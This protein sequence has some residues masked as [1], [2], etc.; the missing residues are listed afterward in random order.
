MSVTVRTEVRLR[1]TDTSLAFNSPASRYSDWERS[2]EGLLE[3]SAARMAP[4]AVAEG[5]TI[6]KDAV[7]PWREA[8][9]A[10]AEELARVER[11]SSSRRLRPPAAAPTAMPPTKRRRPPASAP[12]TA[13]IISSV[14]L[15]ALPSVFTAS[16]SAKAVKMPVCHSN[17]DVSSTASGT[18]PATAASSARIVPVARA[19]LNAAPV[20]GLKLRENATAGCS[21]SVVCST[22][23]S[24]AV[25]EGEGEGVTEGVAVRVAV[26]DADAEPEEE[27]DAEPDRERLRVEDGDSPSLGV[28]AEVPVPAGSPA[29][30]VGVAVSDRVRV[31][32]GEFTAVMVPEVVAQPVD[33]KTGVMEPACPPRSAA[34]P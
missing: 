27:E 14:L 34:P 21:W 9:A 1:P 26:A 12:P 25:V 31:E 24:D 15:Y 11:N 30:P 20:P 5:A 22:M 3:R 4:A 32:V 16:L 8:S 6:T 2:L 23:P 28:G 17:T 18:A 33:V 10:K 19:S 13:S 29:V 7:A